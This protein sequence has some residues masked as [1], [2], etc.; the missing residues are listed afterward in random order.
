MRLN[1]SIENQAIS[2]TEAVELYEQLDGKEITNLQ[3][4]DV[5]KGYNS[6]DEKNVILIMPAYGDCLLIVTAVNPI[7]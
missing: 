3:G 5:V 1:L 2:Y 4:V 7:E 6:A